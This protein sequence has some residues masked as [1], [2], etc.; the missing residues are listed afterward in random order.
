MKF[1]L[2]LSVLC[3]TLALCQAACFIK[4]PKAEMRNG[5][6]VPQTLCTDPY[7]GTQHLLGSKW[8]TAHCL[9]CSCHSGEMT[10]CHRYGG[11]AIAPNGCDARV[12]PD[13]C[14]YEMYRID[15]PSEPC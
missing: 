6:L 15:N 10:C 13:T 5:V 3:I 9:E 4:L 14:Q 12:N 2:S 7:D 8:N 1:L 11:I